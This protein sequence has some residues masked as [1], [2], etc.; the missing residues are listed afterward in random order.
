MRKRIRCQSFPVGLSEKSDNLIW[1]PFRRLLFLPAPQLGFENITI[2][3]FA[4]EEQLAFGSIKN[5]QILRFL[6]RILIFI[7]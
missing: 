2:F 1:P 7:L 3:M 5:W 4:Q 6:W